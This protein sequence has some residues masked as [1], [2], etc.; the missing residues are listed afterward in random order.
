MTTI[1]DVAEAAGVSMGTVS[2]ALKTLK[3][4]RG[5]SDETRRLVPRV[6]R[7][8]GYDTGRLRGR[9]TRRLVLLGHHQHSS[10]TANPFFAHVLH[11]VEDACR[12]FGAAPTLLATG[13][14]E[15]IVRASTSTTSG[16]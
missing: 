2:R 16:K 10:F 9:N 1:R 8:L 11:G 3:N 6:A 4:R 14:V 13:P 5:L 12:G 7:Q 15:L